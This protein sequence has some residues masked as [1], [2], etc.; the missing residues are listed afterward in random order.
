[1]NKLHRPGLTLWHTFAVCALVAMSTT[2]TCESEDY[3]AEARSQHA[4]LLPAE[5]V[6]LRKNGFVIYDSK[7]AAAETIIMLF[8]GE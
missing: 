7:V 4:A 1:M 3:S 6:T 2:L 8:G 5:P